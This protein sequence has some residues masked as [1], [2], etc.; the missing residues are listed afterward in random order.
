MSVNQNGKLCLSF[1]ILNEVQGLDG[2][3]DKSCR[4]TGPSLKLSIPAFEADGRFT[5]FNNHGGDPFAT[6]ETE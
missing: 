1:V 4:P 6:G 2:L 5:V 3:L